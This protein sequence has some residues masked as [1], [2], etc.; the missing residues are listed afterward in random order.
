MSTTIKFPLLIIADTG[1]QLDNAISFARQ[2]LGFPRADLFTVRHLAK[3]EEPQYGTDYQTMIQLRQV[4]GTKRAIIS[5]S[6]ELVKH[7]G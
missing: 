3:S 2:M 5:V 6:D 7:S 1:S 4:H